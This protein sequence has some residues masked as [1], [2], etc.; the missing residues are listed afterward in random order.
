MAERCAVVLCEKDR[1]LYEN[2]YDDF[3]YANQWI[4]LTEKCTLDEKIRLGSIL[5]KKCGGGQIC[6]INVDGQFPNKDMAWEMLNY[7][8]NKGVIYFAFNNKISVCKNGHGFYG[9]ECPKC[10]SPKVDTFQRIVGYLVPSSNYSKERYKE[11]E[12]RY[13]YDLHDSI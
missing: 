13:W 11:F 4:P 2:E 6:H 1:E 12:G 7:I 10:G 9:N 5:D 3:I 8:A